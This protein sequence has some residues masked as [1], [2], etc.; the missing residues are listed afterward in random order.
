[1]DSLAED[2]YVGGIEEFSIDV[3]IGAVEEMSS[4]NGEDLTHGVA[5][6]NY[7]ILVQI[8]CPDKVILLND[9]YNDHIIG[10]TRQQLSKVLIQPTLLPNAPQ[11]PL[12]PERGKIRPDNVSVFSL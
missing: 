2:V 8:G 5:P 11:H 7:A 1:M 12:M 4:T 10:N 3:W 9:L 6:M